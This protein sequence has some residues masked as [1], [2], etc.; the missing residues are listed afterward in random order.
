MLLI[1]AKHLAGV[2]KTPFGERRDYSLRPALDTAQ[3]ALA[4]GLL[5]FG[6]AG[7]IGALIRRGVLPDTAMVAYGLLGGPLI[8]LLVLLVWLLMQTLIQLLYGRKK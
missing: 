7:G 6:W 3:K 1:R 2:A 4:V 5:V 8:V